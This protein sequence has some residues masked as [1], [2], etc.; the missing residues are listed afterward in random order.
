MSLSD[1]WLGSH[2]LPG[3]PG[4]VLLVDVRS[5]TR[6]LPSHPHHQFARAQGRDC[7]QLIFG[8]VVSMLPFGVTLRGLMV[9]ANLIQFQPFREL[10]PDHQLDNVADL[11]IDVNAKSERVLDMPVDE[12]SGEC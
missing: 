4:H 7:R 2:G 1:V 8:V 11:P 10:S 5:S 6:Q 3:E 9:G 12:L